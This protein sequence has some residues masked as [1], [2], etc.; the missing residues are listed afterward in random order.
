MLLA[1]MDGYRFTYC[2]IGVDVHTCSMFVHQFISISAYNNK[3]MKMFIELQIKDI[4]AIYRT[5]TL[6]D[7]L[8]RHKS[9]TT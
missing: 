2:I 4:F 1:E 5:F 7:S 3:I 8:R 6:K 9:A